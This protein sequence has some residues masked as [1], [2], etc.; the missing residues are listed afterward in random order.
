M[1]DMVA[2]RISKSVNH[3]RNNGRKLV[4]ANGGSDGCE[5]SPGQSLPGFLGAEQRSHR[6][7]AQKP[8]GQKFPGEVGSDVA[9]FGNENRQ[10]KR[11]H[12]AINGFL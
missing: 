3:P 10:G 2:Y 5:Q 11:H 6:M 9:A 12:R 1:N 8:S 7:P 4:Q